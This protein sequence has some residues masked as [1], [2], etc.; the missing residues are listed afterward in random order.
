L[1]IYC[2]I[3]QCLKCSAIVFRFIF[4]EIPYRSQL[5]AI[6]KILKRKR[7][8]FFGKVFHISIWMALL[9]SHQFPFVQF[10]L[11]GITIEA[12]LELMVLEGG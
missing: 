11:L 6:A 8:Y 12:I 4:C 1:Q 3:K 10:L 9:F 7:M 2:F 5:R